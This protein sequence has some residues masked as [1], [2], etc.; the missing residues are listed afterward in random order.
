MPLG[1]DGQKGGVFMKGAGLKI[2][3][4]LTKEKGGDIKI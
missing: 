3:F 1:Q 4:S 2:N